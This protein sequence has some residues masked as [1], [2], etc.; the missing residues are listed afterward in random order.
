MR[1]RMLYLPANFSSSNA[2]SKCISCN[3]N[4]NMEHVY[5]CVEWNSEEE[6]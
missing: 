4:E 1:N 6:Q 2:E 3:E 5:K